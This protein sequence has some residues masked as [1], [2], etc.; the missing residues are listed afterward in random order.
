MCCLQTAP[1]HPPSDRH[2]QSLKAYAQALPPCRC[3]WQATRA[4]SAHLMRQAFCSLPG[5]CPAQT[6]MT[7]SAR[8]SPCPPSA[9]THKQATSGAGL[10][11]CHRHMA[12]VSSEMLSA[13][14][15]QST[16]RQVCTLSSYKAFPI[17]STVTN[18][19]LHKDMPCLNLGTCLDHLH[20]QQ[21]AAGSA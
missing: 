9:C 6:F 12:C 8:Q 18:T 13:I 7:P 11:R 10:S 17:E 5:T 4:I 1:P 3:C 20:E 14:S 19:I 15:T 21:S 2:Q 16:A